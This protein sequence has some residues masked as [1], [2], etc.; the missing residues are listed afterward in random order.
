MLSPAN[1]V[2]EADRLYRQS[3]AAAYLRELEKRHVEIFGMRT[4]R[5]LWQLTTAKFVE[6]LLLSF[7]HPIEYL[8]SH[9]QVVNLAHKLYDVIFSSDLAH[10]TFLDF[11]YAYANV[12]LSDTV[13]RHPDA[14]IGPAHSWIP[15]SDQPF[16]SLPDLYLPGG[17]APVYRHPVLVDNLPRLPSGALDWLHMTSEQVKYAM[18]L[19]APEEM[20]A[21]TR[22]DAAN[23]ALINK[24]NWLPNAIYTGAITAAAV[25]LTALTA[26]AAAG[27]L[28]VP[29]ADVAAGGIEMGTISGGEGLTAFG[30][31]YNA[32]QL[33]KY[34]GFVAP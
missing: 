3:A 22:N 4:V 6:L 20:S 10:R 25:G 5:Q 15:D 30:E 16:S 21:A 33:G 9:P 11:G 24:L 1:P 7:R 8:S 23:V 28:W 18:W 26:G 32:M 31:G 27:A 2:S 17:I 34:A 29:F 12:A 14:Q 19:T 13:L